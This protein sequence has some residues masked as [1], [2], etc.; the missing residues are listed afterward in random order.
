MAQEMIAMLNGIEPPTRGRSEQMSLAAAPGKRK[1]VNTKHYIVNCGGRKKL[2]SKFK[3][4]KT[5]IAA[6]KRTV[7]N[8]RGPKI[9]VV[10][11]VKMV[12]SKSASSRR[13]IKK[14]SMFLDPILAAARTKNGVV[15]TNR[16]STRRG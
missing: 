7:A 16:V 4:A 3:K 1:T 2:K 11:P 5:A 13:C 8:P 9:C 14:K 15:E 6:A 10:Q 12:C